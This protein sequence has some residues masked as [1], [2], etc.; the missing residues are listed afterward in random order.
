[1]LRRQFIERELRQIYGGY[2]P[3]DSEITFELVNKWLSEATGIAAKQCYKEAYQMDAV[4]YVNNS[5]YTTFKGISAT[6]D[7]NFLWKI[8]LPQI[9]VGVGKDEGIASL[10][11]K[12]SDNQVS[13]DCVPLSINERG[14]YAN[15]RRIP[16][17]VL[18]YSE[19]ICLYVIS[20][21]LLN[22]YTATV[23]LISGGDSTDLNSVLNLPDDYFPVISEYIKTQLGFERAQPK[24]QAADGT[25]NK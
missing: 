23:T 15:Q 19:G 17:K 21:L 25:D 1:M 9:P 10:K 2:I 11:F 24:D 18:Y 14:F 12:S 5:F 22:Q 20:T 7:E 6:Q 3:D 8:T 16:N 4:A 13:L